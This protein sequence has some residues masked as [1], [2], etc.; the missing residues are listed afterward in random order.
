[1]ISFPPIAHVAVT[2]H[3]LD[4]SVSWYARLFDADPVLDED[5]G[6][7][8]HVVWAVGDTPFGLHKFPIG[9]VA[10]DRADWLLTAV[11]C[12][13]VRPSAMGPAPRERR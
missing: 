13:A 6:P 12:V 10:T 8:R 5:T 3:D 4:V 1:M 11:V 2:V 7:F 9:D